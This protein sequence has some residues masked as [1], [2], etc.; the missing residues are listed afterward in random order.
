MKAKTVINFLLVFLGA[1]V[2]NYFV[3]LLVPNK[4]VGMA[5]VMITMIIIFSA[6]LL[7]RLEE[8][9]K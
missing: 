3:M 7:D 2:A 5:I 4:S 8:K 6:L 9:D 1:T